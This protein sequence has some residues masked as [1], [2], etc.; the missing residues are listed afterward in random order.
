M[1]EMNHCGMEGGDMISI[2]SLFCRDVF[3]LV[4]TNI[5]C[6]DIDFL[7]LSFFFVVVFPHSIS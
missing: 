6:E 2:L 1:F 4:D 7:S 3:D 5:I